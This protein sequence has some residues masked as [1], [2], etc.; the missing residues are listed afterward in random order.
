MS[1]ADQIIKEL[2]WDTEFFGCKIGRVNPEDGDLEAQDFVQIDKLAKQQRFKC[3]YLTLDTNR[4]HELSIA[5]QHGFIVYDTRVELSLCLTSEDKQKQNADS[6]TAPSAS[7]YPIRLALPE[8]IEPLKEMAASSFHLSRFYQDPHFP[9]PLCDRLYATWIESEVLDEKVLVWV[10]Q[11]NQALSQEAP[12][13]VHPLG[14]LSLKFK[15]NKDAQISLV[16]V[17]VKGK[18]LGSLLI[19]KTLSEIKQQGITS[20][21]VA[22]QASNEGALRL[23]QKHGF[24]EQTRSANMHKWYS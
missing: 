13:P 23:Y 17:A 24:K 21:T 8:D 1:G 16:G 18:G 10:I 6:D 15:S 5:Q 3:L 9:K 4:D 22:T 7:P 12:Q 14:F 2:T 19:Q 20:V 11:T